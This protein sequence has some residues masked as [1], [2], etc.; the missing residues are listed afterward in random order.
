MKKADRIF[1]ETYKECFYH[2]S[3]FGYEFNPDGKAIGFTGLITNETTSTRTYNAIQKIIDKKIALTNTDFELSVITENE[4][5]KE[6]Y[7]LDIVQS[8]LN[9]HIAVNE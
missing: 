3:R 5:K 9:N 2:F 7:V 6:L 8:T 4:L 1:I